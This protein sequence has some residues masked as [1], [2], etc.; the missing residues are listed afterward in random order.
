M[1]YRVLHVAAQL[2]HRG[3]GL[4][5]RLDEAWPWANDLSQAFVKLRGAS[6]DRVG[7][8]ARPESRPAGRDIR[9]RMTTPRCSTP[10]LRSEHPGR[11]SPLT[12]Q[13]VRRQLRVGRMIRG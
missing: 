12:R 10:S 2:V 13:R 4:I 11:S 5:L 3:R 6:P 9:T 8:N 7:H 1:R